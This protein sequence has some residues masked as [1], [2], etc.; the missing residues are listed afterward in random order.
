MKSVGYK[1]YKLNTIKS[2]CSQLLSALQFLHSHQCTHT[3]IKVRFSK[4]SRASNFSLKIFCSKASELLSSRFPAIQ[5]RAVFSVLKLSSLISA[6]PYLKAT[7]IQKRSRRGIIER[8]KLFTDMLGT[9]KSISGRSAACFLSIIPETRCLKRTKIL[10]ISRLWKDISVHKTEY[11]FN[12]SFEGAP[13]VSVMQKVPKFYAKNSRSC[14]LA[15]D[16][17]C[18]SGKKARKAGFR[19]S[20]RYIS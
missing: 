5:N 3:D 17:E 2:F 4:A 14:H 18:D 12:S 13:P 8:P 16:W 7:I 6:L 19:A 1:P 11:F 20:S 15:I 10:N 9:S